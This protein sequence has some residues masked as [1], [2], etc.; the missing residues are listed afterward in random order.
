[1]QRLKKKTALGTRPGPSLVILSRYDV[2]LQVVRLRPERL[3]GCDGVHAGSHWFW[4]PWWSVQ[5]PR[6][7]SLFKLTGAELHFFVR[8]VYIYIYVYIQILVDVYIHMI[9]DVCMCVY[10]T[11][12]L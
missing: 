6:S 12:I 2:C 4:I 11:Y 1:M 5:G 8:C 10:S 9:M 3:C 7:G